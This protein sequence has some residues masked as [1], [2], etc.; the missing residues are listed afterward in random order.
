MDVTFLITRW[1]HLGTAILACGMIWTEL[2]VIQPAWNGSPDDSTSSLQRTLAESLAQL[3]HFLLVA[4]LVSGLA[5]FALVVWM[6]EGTTP[7]LDAIVYLVTQSTARTVLVSTQFGRI[8]SIHVLLAAALL[9]VKR[10]RSAAVLAAFYL[11]SIAAIGHA[12]SIPG[13]EGVALM[14]ADAMHLIAAGLWLGGLVTLVLLLAALKETSATIALPIASHAAKRFSLIGLIAVIFLAVSGTANAAYLVGSWNGLSD[15]AYG[16]WVVAKISLFALMLA[17]A[18]TNRFYLMPR[19][20]RPATLV[21]LNRNIA[22]ELML[23]LCIVAIVSYL[24]TM[25]PGAHHHH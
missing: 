11:G 24:G 21:Q 14:L 25:A 20:D 17:L 12:G 6:I 10:G 13:N 23:G 19:W 3:I 4:S 5:W 1:I 15:N 18:A 8:W 9:G 16:R 22:L 7:S 2:Q